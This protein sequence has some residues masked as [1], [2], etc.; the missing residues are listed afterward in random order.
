MI[1]RTKALQKE[2]MECA[3]VH[4]KKREFN[5]DILN[6]ERSKAER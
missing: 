2:L 4:S 5:K 3:D 1:I 6:A